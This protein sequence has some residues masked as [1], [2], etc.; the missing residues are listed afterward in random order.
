MEILEKGPRP[1]IKPWKG[2]I[3]LAIGLLVAGWLLNT[4]PG[5]LGKADAVGYAVCHRID[6]RS[7]HL[8]DRQIPLCARCTG[9][10]LGAL[11][12]LVYQAV[13]GGRRIGTP[14]LRVI[15]ILGIFVLSFAID[16]ANSYLH[17]FPGAPALYEPNNTL[18]LLTG[19]GMGLAIAA[20]LFP[21][22]NQSVWRTWNREPA[23]EG[24]RS[25]GVLLAL[26]ALLDLIV[27][28]E[29]PLALYPLALISAG[30]VLVLL[31]MVY[32]MVW[33]IVLRFEN[34]FD[35]LMEMILPLAGG[36]AMSLLQ[37]GLLD[38]GRFL[39]TGTWDGFHIG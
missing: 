6:L 28:S 37:V 7:F 27:L 5:L 20:A 19:T 24:I 1:Q 36:F 8:G 10:F 34:R 13:V 21:A 38:L 31:T 25:L 32:T 22:F 39:L 11:L 26:S 3:F 4:P 23:L 33:L 2:L 29:N 18:R 15:L 35:H 9:M 17:L 16:G 14:P 12:G 30:G